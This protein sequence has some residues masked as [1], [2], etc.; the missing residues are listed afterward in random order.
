M[1]LTI[2]Q[3]QGGEQKMVR[4]Y[5]SMLNNMNTSIAIISSATNIKKWY[6]QLLKMERM[7]LE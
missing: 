3:P 1:H 6:L 5:P 7:T 2:L 4:R